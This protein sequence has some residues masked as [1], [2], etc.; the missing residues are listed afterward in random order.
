[1]SLLVHRR[2]V[3]QPALVCIYGGH[4]HIVLEGEFRSLARMQRPCEVSQIEGTGKASFKGKKCRSIGVE[5]LGSV[6]ALGVLS[7]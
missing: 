3:S 5:I 4:D 6:A 1:M 2:S 7:E